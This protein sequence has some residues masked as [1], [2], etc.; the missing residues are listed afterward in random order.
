MSVRTYND[1]AVLQRLLLTMVWT[2]SAIWFVGLKPEWMSNDAILFLNS[3][4]AVFIAMTGHVI[5]NFIFEGRMPGSHKVIFL[6]KLPKYYLVSLVSLK[7]ASWSGFLA[8]F[9]PNY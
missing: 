4:R 8:W 2:F 1:I 7:L 9:L 6:R 5:I 3:T